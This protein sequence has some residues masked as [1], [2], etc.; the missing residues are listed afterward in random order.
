[1]GADPEVLG[2]GELAVKGDFLGEKADDREEVLVL[3]GRASEHTGWRP[4]ETPRDRVDLRE[5]GRRVAAAQCAHLGGQA[6]LDPLDS[7]LAWPRDQLAGVPA[8]P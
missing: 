2:G 5:D 8:Q 1:M 6:L 4:P 7:G 3:R